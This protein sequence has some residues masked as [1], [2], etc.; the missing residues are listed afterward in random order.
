MCCKVEFFSYF[1]NRKS[2]F[3]I[4]ECT[5]E[6]IIFKA[7]KQKCMGTDFCKSKISIILSTLIGQY[8]IF[9]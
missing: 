8:T 3:S 9:I 1:F 7:I 2:A 5:K 6:Y 4:T